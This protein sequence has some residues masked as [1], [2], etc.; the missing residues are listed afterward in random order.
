[1][2]PQQELRSAILQASVKGLINFGYF[3]VT[4][5]NIL[6]DR[7]YST[8]LGEILT[9]TLQEAIEYDK[10]LLIEVIESLQAEIKND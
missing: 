1:M 4:V 2:T 6:T 3:D 5:T 9:S 7:I 8:F 10:T